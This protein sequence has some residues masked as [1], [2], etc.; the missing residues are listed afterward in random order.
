MG[1]KKSLKRFKS[2]Q[3]VYILVNT[4]IPKPWNIK[5]ETWVVYQT[6]S[7]ISKMYKEKKNN[8]VV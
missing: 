7:L 3:S 6:A 4:H 2:Y 5:L 8:F 1:K